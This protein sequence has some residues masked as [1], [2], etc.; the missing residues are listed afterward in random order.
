MYQRHDRL[1]LFLR[2][3]FVETLTRLHRR[4]RDSGLLRRIDFRHVG[5]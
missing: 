4:V 3:Q 2:S 5:Q 1:D